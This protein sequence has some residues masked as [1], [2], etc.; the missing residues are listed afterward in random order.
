VQGSRICRAQLV[1]TAC[2]ED[3]AVR[4]VGV[5]FLTAFETTSHG[6]KP[7]FDLDPLLRS[8]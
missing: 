5:A 6:Q 4:A 7:A 8:R 3:S 2:R 1:M